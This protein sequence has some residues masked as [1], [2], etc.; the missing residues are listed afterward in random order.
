[1]QAGRLNQKITIQAKSVTRDAFNAEVI[2]WTTHAT[3][4][5]EA[6]PISGR[7]YVALRAA[8]SDISIRFRLRYLPGV[9]TAMRVLW[10]GQTYDIVEAINV[11]ARNTE[12]E[13]LCRGDQVSA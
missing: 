12:L 3:V 13:L 6:V 9:S 5:A 7:E 2:T 1:M 10:N 4:W 8:Q 11:N